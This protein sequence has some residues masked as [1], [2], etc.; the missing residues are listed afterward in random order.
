MDLMILAQMYVSIKWV[1]PL[2]V[3]KG[4]FY[5]LWVIAIYFMVGAVFE[6]ARTIVG[7]ISNKQ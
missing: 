3:N 5:A 6:M 7:K 4:A 2:V 1:L